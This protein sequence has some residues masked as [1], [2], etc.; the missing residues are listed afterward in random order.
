MIDGLGRNSYFTV[1]DARSAYWSIELNPDDR[2][3]TAF[4]DGTYLW[5]FHCMPYGLK[6]AGA[7]YQRMINFVLSPVLGRHTVAYLDDVVVYSRDFKEYLKHLDET[8][9]L[10]KEVGFKMNLKAF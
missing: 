4:S 8:L 1:L 2:P 7:T 10:I 6:T 5:Q 9:Q 3:R